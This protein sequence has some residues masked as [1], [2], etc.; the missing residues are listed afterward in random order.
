MSW[1]TRRRNGIITTFGLLVLIIVGT[2]VF[3]VF[4]E[5]ANCFD[6]KQNGGEAGIDCGGSC[7]LM[8]RHQIIEP[9]VHWQRLFEVAPGIYNVLAYVEN[10][11][12][13]AGVDEVGYTFGIYDADNV[14]LQERRGTMKLPPKAIVPVI[15]NTLSAGTLRAARVSFSFTTDMVWKR[16]ESEPAHL[17]IADEELLDVATAPRIEAQLQNTNIAP[18]RNVRVLAILYDR[19][20]NALTTSSTLADIVPAGSS[21]PIFFTWP[22]PFS[23]TVARIELI[24]LYERSPR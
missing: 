15:E 17:V 10:P 12:P 2:Y 21:V 20:D 14:L 19:S 4:Y 9:V 3:T 6:G 24:P 22:R 18:I 23:D 8:C 5:P 7:E 16:R 13:E 11:N 1:G